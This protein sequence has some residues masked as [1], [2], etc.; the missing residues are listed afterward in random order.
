M[1]NTI[2]TQTSFSIIVGMILSNALLSMF[3]AY[4]WYAAILMFA[5]LGLV[6]AWVQK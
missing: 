4:A 5:I 1:K 6:D 3:N 2:F